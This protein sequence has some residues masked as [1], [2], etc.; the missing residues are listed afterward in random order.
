MAGRIFL[1]AAI[2]GREGSLK[3]AV[4][5]D[6]IIFAVDAIRHGVMAHPTAILDARLK[7]M[8]RRSM[9]VRESLS[10]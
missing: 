9:A 5:L 1:K 7:E 3:V 8:R 10:V 6:A 4:A 2:A